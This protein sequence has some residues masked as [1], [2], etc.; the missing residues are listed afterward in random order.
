MIHHLLVSIEVMVTFDVL[1][2]D[3]LELIV[4][5]Q[6]ISSELRVIIVELQVIFIINSIDIML[7]CLFYIVLM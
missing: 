2:L 7:K 6:V 4:E 1:K 3:F 5:L